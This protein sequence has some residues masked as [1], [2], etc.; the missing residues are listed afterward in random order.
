MKI[1]I[2]TWASSWLWK[3]FVYNL[4][5]EKDIDQIRVLAR[6]TDKLNELKK[7]YWDKIAHIL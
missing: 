4:I 5:K 2:V 7:E 1:A 3:I 6:S